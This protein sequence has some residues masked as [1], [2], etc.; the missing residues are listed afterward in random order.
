LGY[1]SPVS[2]AMTS[3]Q[4]DNAALNP[5]MMMSDIGRM[6]KKKAKQKVAVF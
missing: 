6:G 3:K 2:N 4:Y 5:L 1:F